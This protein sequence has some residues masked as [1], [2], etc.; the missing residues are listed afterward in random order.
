LHRAVVLH[1]KLYNVDLERI[2]HNLD[3][4]DGHGYLSAKASKL[5]EQYCEQNHLDVAEQI[6]KA[7]ETADF[8]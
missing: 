6:K 5:F 8:S 4:P 2:C 3:Q 7:R 1:R